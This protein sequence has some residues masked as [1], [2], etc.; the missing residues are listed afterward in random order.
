MRHRSFNKRLMVAII[1]SA[2]LLVAHKDDVIKAQTGNW[3]EPE[4]TYNW[5][6]REPDERYKA[7]VLVIVAHSDDE[8]LV[9][10]YCARAIDQKRRVAIVWM[11]DTG[12]S[13]NGGLNAG[14][15]GTVRLAGSHPR[16]RRDARRRRPGRHQCL[17]FGR[18]RH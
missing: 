8:S 3:P 5:N 4:D 14:W 1:L 18:F 12:R 15:S 9:A 7:D 16:A 13:L 17:E 2:S 11:N 6:N 10:A